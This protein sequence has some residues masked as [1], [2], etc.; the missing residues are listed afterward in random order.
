LFGFAAEEHPVS[1]PRFGVSTHLYHDKR[2]DRE[3]L[4]E[5]AA[6]GFECLEV[7]ATRTHFDYHDGAAVR[8]LAEWLDDTRLTLHSMHAPITASLTNGDWGETF[9]TAVSDEERRRKT[10][11]EAE[12]ALAVAQ[13]IQFKYLVVHLGVP[14]VMK[15]GSGENSREAARRSV[16]ALHDLAK[17][18]GVQLALEVIPNAL[19]TPESLVALIENDLEDLN[20]GI[21][22]DVGHAHIMGDLNDAI[23]HCAGHIWTTHLHDNRGK[24]DDHLT[25]GHGSIDWPATIME[26]QKVGYDGVWMF[27][28]ANTSDTKT[29][30]EKTEKARRKFESLLDLSFDNPTV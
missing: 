30:L 6:H 27:E 13:T 22:V 10:L 17:R 16:E 9:S 8:A 4:V 1:N 5:I 28:V 18:S 7:F 19:S 15:P 26:F 14:D 24:S 3:H 21:C 25:P 11:T 29:V 12:A 20:V 2:L 23:E